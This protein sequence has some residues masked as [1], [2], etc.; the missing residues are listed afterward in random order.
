MYE[1]LTGTHALNE[2]ISATDAKAHA[3]RKNRRVLYCNEHPDFQIQNF[4]LAKEEIAPACSRCLP[5]LSQ[6]FKLKHRY[7]EIDTVEIIYERIRAVVQN[8]KKEFEKESAMLKEMH[9]DNK[10]A[11]ENRL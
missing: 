11:T 9:K 5:D 8:Y 7:M 2:G 10:T 1:F 3:V 6:F 4:V